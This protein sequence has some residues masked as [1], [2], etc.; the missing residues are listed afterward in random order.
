MQINTTKQS[1]L[2]LYLNFV[3]SLE[4]FSTTRGKRIRH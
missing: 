4:T 3:Q 2:E 1:G